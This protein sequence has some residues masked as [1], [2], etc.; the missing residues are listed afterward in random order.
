M[1]DGGALARPQPLP[2][3]SLACG[4]RY[5]VTR[6]KLLAVRVLECLYLALVFELVRPDMYHFL[7]IVIYWIHS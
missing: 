4:K 5:G 3:Q 1:L 2:A 6:A 7:G